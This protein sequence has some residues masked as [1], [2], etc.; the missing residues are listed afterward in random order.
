[1]SVNLQVDIFFIFLIGGA[2]DYGIDVLYNVFIT[3]FI[4]VW[5]IFDPKKSMDVWTAAML[6]FDTMETGC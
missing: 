2:A 6:K 1:M 5:C 3:V 4:I